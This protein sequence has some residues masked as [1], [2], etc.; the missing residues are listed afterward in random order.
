MSHIYVTQSIYS[1]R[2]YQIGPIHYK[3]DYIA[4]MR[5]ISIPAIWNVIWDHTNLFPTLNQ[6]PNTFKP[7]NRYSKVANIG[8]PKSLPKIA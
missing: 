6:L 5:R 2:S 3:C 7:K 8:F 4:S 1:L